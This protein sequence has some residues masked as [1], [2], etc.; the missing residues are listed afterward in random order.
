MQS[1]ICSLN[2]DCSLV[3]GSYST[4][5]EETAIILDWLKSFLL[6]DLIKYLS[7]FHYYAK[8]ER[9]CSLKKKS[10]VLL[11]IDHITTSERCVMACCNISP[12][13]PFKSLS[14]TDSVCT[15]RH[16]HRYSPKGVWASE[17]CVSNFRHLAD[18]WI[19]SDFHIFIYM[20]I[21]ALKMLSLLKDNCSY[22]VWGL[23]RQA[24]LQL[25]NDLRGSY[26]RGYFEGTRLK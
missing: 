11:H 14:D 24:S 22:T 2:W 1:L 4:C 18:A 3:W 23:S 12:S 5:N 6:L 9:T 17:H 8:F 25:S 7:V 19:M 21:F 13:A 26:G 15:D 20:Y 16:V 10:F